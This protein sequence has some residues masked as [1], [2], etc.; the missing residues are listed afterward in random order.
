MWHLPPSL[1]LGPAA[2]PTLPLAILIA[3]LVW[4]GPAAVI[5]RRLGITSDQLGTSVTGLGIAGLIGSRLALLASYPRDFFATPRALLSVG[6]PVARWGA[7]AGV[8]LYAGWLVWRQRR[9]AWA[10]L[11]AALAGAPLPLAIVAVGWSDPGALPAAIGLTVAAL[12]LLNARAPA[13]PGQSALAAVLL[14]TIVGFALPWF[15]LAS[16]DTVAVWP[17]WTLTQWALLLVGIAAGVGLW[18]LEGKAPP[19]AGQPP[20]GE[21]PAPGESP[22]STEPPA[23]SESPS[24]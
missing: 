24:S 20:S 19:S 15:R 6:G 18:L 23:P 22:L 9:E 4:P 10:W 21:S 13:Q 14:L 1:P 2:L 17:G 7:V 3:L 16:P 5:G 8:V 11:E 12:V